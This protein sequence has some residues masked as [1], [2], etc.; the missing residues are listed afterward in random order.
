MKNCPKYKLIRPKKRERH[1]DSER[2]IV[3]ISKLV[4]VNTEIELAEN[5]LKPLFS[6]SLNF[7]D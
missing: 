6:D 1:K 7:E 2:I 5:T 4:I 3:T